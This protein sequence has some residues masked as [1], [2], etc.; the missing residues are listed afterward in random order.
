M[1]DYPRVVQL[2][3]TLDPQFPGWVSPGVVLDPSAAP[4]HLDEPGL[5]TLGAT[6]EKPQAHCATR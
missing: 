5:A 4:V 1:Y 2:A 3:G 6:S